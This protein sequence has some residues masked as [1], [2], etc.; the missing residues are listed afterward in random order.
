MDYQIPEEI[1]HE[2]F[3]TYDIRGEAGEIG[4]TPD[5]AYA[6]GLAIGSE[7]R[8]R[9]ITSLVVGRDGRLTGPIIKDAM[10]TGLLETGCDLIDVGTVPTP[11]VYFATNRLS[12]NSG[13]MVTAS[14][15]PASHNGFKIVLD[16]MT[17]STE[18]VQALYQ[19]IVD[20]N[21]AIGVGSMTS[22]DIVTDYVNFITAQIQ[23]KKPLKVV[24][25]CGNG[26]AGELVPSLYRALGC[27]VIEMYCEV[28]GRFPN[29]H[30][31]P[32]VLD[33]LKDIIATVKKEK[34]DI[35]L[36]FDGDADRLGVITNAGEVIWPD[37]Q[38]MLYAIDVLSRNPG[39]DI[40]F[41]VK[42]TNHLPKVIRAHGGNP[43]MYRTGHSVLKAKMIEVGAVLA[44]E[45]SG[46]IF[47]KEDW[48]GFDDGI[49][50]GARLL[51]I[52]SNDDR[53][54]S[55]VFAALPNSINTPELK[56]PMAEDKK[57]HFMQRLLTEAIFD[58]A[59]RITIDGLRVEF[60]E[61]WGLVRASNTSP[62]LIL[63]FEADTKD[64]LDHIK[65]L[66]RQQ[67]LSLDA[68]LD[69]PF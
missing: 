15:N 8:D 33:N 13:V 65:S 43:I 20:R 38:M 7:A 68:A 39:A 22:A 69:L 28:D 30:P 16:G 25:D 6:I 19:R 1:P 31:D 34:A 21:F 61:G 12:T 57:A 17:L 11:L 56:L 48:F 27:E 62:Y 52:L 2:V 58:D 53:T 59:E 18:G 50:V 47:F 10:V 29:H 9:G 23:I 64:H 40:V 60:K 14:H 4:I 46:H 54:S 5:V 35:G 49:Y 24:I 55:E 42:C 41:D 45:M 51:R 32:T 36:A 26:I 44:G 37:R 66:F 67:L 63:R 3:R